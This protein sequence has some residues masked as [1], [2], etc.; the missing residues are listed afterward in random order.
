MRPTHIGA[1]RRTE[2]LGGG[3]VE[4]VEAAGIEPAPICRVTADQPGRWL[5]GEDWQK[6]AMAATAL[7]GSK[8][9]QERR[10]R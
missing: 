1:T 8:H 4:N 10:R 9:H 7:P 2:A 5:S 3:V 6:A